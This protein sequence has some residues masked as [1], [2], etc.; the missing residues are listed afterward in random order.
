M[1]DFS[2]LA[3]GIMNSKRPKPLPSIVHIRVEHSVYC[4]KQ[5][6]CDE[7][8]KIFKSVTGK[9]LDFT[10][11]NGTVLWLSDFTCLIIGGCIQGD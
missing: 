9:E 6:P 2:I 8:Y 4:A 7:A 5:I 11:K 10:L 3:D 1:S